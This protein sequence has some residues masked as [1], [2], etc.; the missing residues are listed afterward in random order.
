MLKDF[1]DHDDGVDISTPGHFFSSVLQFSTDT[2]SGIVLH[3]WFMHSA[4]LSSCGSFSIGTI[5]HLYGDG[6]AVLAM[7]LP[8]AM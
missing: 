3:C 2:D 1:T 4:K 6:T 8:A 5:F 7:F